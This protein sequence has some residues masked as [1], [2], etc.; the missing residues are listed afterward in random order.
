MKEIKITEPL[1][2]PEEKA[3]WF[4]IKILFWIYGSIIGGLLT[5]IFIWPYIYWRLTGRIK[6]GKWVKKP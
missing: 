6:D 3:E 2:T 5:V 1:P 4:R